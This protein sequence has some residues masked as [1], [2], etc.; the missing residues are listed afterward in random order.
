MSYYKIEDHSFRFQA[1]DK[2]VSKNASL[3]KM[4]KYGVSDV[5]IVPISVAC[6]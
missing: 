3:N 1:N 5:I 4:S 2:N 6:A